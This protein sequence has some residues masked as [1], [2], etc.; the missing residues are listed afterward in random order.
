M[1][2]KYRMLESPCGGKEAQHLTR[3]F[4]GLSAPVCCPTEPHLATDID[5][6]GV[7]VIEGQQG[8]IA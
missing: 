4:S 3:P 1:I 2:S 5:H 8:P 6:T 7:W